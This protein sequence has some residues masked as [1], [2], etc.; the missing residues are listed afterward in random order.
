MKFQ[1]MCADLRQ[2]VR[3]R[4]RLDAEY[5]HSDSRLRSTE[6]ILAEDL[7]NLDNFR[8]HV[9]K[10]AESLDQA[11]RQ[12]E[13]RVEAQRARVVEARRKFELL[14]HLKRQKQEAWRLESLKEEETLASELFLAKWNRNAGTRL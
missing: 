10:Q 14:D 3:Q 4:K 11:G 2:I 6:T 12:C 7:G 1:Q 5:A 13:K 9:R 8:R